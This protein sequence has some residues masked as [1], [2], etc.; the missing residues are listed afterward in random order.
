MNVVIFKISMQLIFFHKE[1]EIQVIFN[2]ILY[3]CIWILFSLI[4]PKFVWA[5]KI[6]Q[7]WANIK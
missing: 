7:L 5:Q 4:I 6:K 3:I 1:K 2:M